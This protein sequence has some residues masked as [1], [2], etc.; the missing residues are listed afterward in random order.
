[1]GFQG[2]KFNFKKRGVRTSYSTPLLVPFS[3]SIRK[4]CHGMLKRYTKF[5]K[6]PIFA[7]FSKQ[8]ILTY[9][10]LIHL[11]LVSQTRSPSTEIWSQQ[12]QRQKPQVSIR[13]NLEITTR[14]APLTNSVFK[15]YWGIM[16][17]FEGGPGPLRNATSPPRDRVAARNLGTA[18]KAEFLWHNKWS[19]KCDQNGA[20]VILTS[21]SGG[22]CSGMWQ[23]QHYY[24]LF[25]LGV[26]LFFG[27]CCVLGSCMCNNTVG[28]VGH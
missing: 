12:R 21:R 7:I 23:G 15:F 27:K 16:R 25:S 22:Q 4:N 26:V 5:R 1:M 14:P 28:Q 3:P 24:I 6:D 18:A 9:L 13:A 17:P 20:I 2:A 11:V 19:F 8:G 10:I